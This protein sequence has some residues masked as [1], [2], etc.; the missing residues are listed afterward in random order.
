VE[1]IALTLLFFASCVWM[2]KGLTRLM[3]R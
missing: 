2:V 3:G 1:L